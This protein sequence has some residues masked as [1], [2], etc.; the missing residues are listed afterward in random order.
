MHK[1]DPF[2][3]IPLYE[4]RRDRLLEFME[5]LSSRSCV[6]TSD[7]L[8]RYLG[9]ELEVLP[10]PITLSVFIAAAECT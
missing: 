3:K 10:T 6:S 1:N 4:L 7:M 9:L 2:Q 8:M 5:N